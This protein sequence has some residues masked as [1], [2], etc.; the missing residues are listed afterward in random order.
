MRPARASPAQHSARIM[1]QHCAAPRCPARAEPHA[2]L[3]HRC[4]WLVAR[5]LGGA[6][7][8]P[9]ALGL[10]PLEL[11][12]W[13]QQ[14]SRAIWGSPLK[15]ACLELVFAPWVFVCG[16]GGRRSLSV[17]TALSLEKKSTVTGGVGC[18][19]VVN[20]S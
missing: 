4:G 19:R 12:S 20:G 8:A 15:A 5:D 1:V 13:L 3:L 9:K 6:T 2:S 14:R 18:V 7:G 11:L 10:G 17:V 16:R